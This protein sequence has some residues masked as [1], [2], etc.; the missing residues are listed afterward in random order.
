MTEKQQKYIERMNATDGWRLIG[1]SGGRANVE[2]HG[3]KH[4]Q[5]LGSR[6]AEALIK[7]LGGLEKAKLHWSRIGKLKSRKEVE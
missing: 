6:G 7:K 4:M 1:K 2:K 5:E 3:V